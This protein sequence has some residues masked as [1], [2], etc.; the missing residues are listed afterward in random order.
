M[1]VGE[2]TGLSDEQT[3]FRQWGAFVRR[4]M[5]TEIVGEDRGTCEKK[6]SDGGVIN[7]SGALFMHPIGVRAPVDGINELYVCR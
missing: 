4:Q 5:K 2:E 7:R 1:V 6:I 3:P